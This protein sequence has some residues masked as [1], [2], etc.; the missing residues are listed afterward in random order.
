MHGVVSVVTGGGKT[1]FAFLCMRE[2]RKRY[3]NGRIIVVVPTVT[4][5]DQW[6]VGLQHE[7]A[8]PAEE[9]ACFSG[10]EK[11]CPPRAV[12]V[13]VIN[14]ARRKVHEL[15]ADSE[16]FLVVDE[17]HRAGSPENA[18]ALQGDFVATLGLSATP[19]R[20]YDGGFE[21][22]IV[23]TLGPII[24]EYTYTSARQDGVVSPFDL[25]NVQVSMLPHEQTKYD[26]FTKRASILLRRLRAEPG[27]G[28]EEQLRRVLQQRAAVSGNAIMRLPVAARLG[29]SPK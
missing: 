1:V 4:L 2:F 8:V 3:P 12:N 9:I 25:V 14:T 7:F 19:R 13:L 21:E 20:E 23:P 24:F 27:L 17:C 16:S 26:Q 6:A 22:H 5:L 11:A 15:S 18:K 29:L 28:L 10:Q